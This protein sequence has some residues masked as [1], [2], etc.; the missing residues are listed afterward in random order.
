[1]GYCVLRSHNLYMFMHRVIRCH[2]LQFVYN[3]WL[4]V[5]LLENLPVMPGIS[6]DKNTS[7]GWLQLHSAM[8]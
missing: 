3:R 6:G 7:K 8:Y 5:P 4:K 2:G 1:M